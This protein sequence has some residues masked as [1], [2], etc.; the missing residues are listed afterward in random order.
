M[1]E[2]YIARYNNGERNFKEEMTIFDAFELTEI[3]DED[4]VKALHKKLCDK[5]SI[6]NDYFKHDENTYPFDITK[7]NVP[8]NVD[9]FLYALNK[10]LFQQAVTVSGDDDT[11]DY[12]PDLLYAFLQI[13]EHLNKLDYYNNLVPALNRVLDYN[14]GDE[15]YIEVETR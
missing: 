12:F 14:E 8:K 11:Y 2:L 3:L 5:L 9:L 13:C 15:E 6:D 7:V 1:S 10:Q 4:E